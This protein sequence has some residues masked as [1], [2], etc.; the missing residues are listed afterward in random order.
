MRLS[1]I[2]LAAM[3]G[4]TSALAADGPVIDPAA[5]KA[6]FETLFADLCE[7]A[8]RFGL[9]GDYAPETHEIVLPPRYA[10]GGERRFVLYGFPCN[11]GAYNATSVWLVEG[12]HGGLM[13][14]SFASPQLEFTYSD[15]RETVLESYAVVGFATSV[16]LVNAGFDPGT[17]T[18][19]D[20]GKW[21]G[22]GDASSSGRWE[23]TDGGFVLREYEVDPTLDG[24]IDPFVA[25]R[26]DAEPQRPAPPD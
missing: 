23:F 2:L 18:M 21:R 25:Y 20:F 19:A 17:R 24:E 3:A 5:A 1:L 11:R 22:L 14:A 6:R 8:L 7:G 9:F 4:P 26:A 13:P 12:E 15:A 16:E 10:G